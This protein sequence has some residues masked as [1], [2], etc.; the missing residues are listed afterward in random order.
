MGWGGAQR[1]ARQLRGERQAQAS[2]VAVAVAQ[3]KGGQGGEAERA[4]EVCR[5][6]TSSLWTPEVFRGR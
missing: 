3:E 1:G 2:A 6:L 5:E 4:E